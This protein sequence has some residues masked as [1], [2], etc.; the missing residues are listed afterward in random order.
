MKHEIFDN[1]KS[2]FL[3]V[4]GTNQYYAMRVKLSP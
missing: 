4:P 1:C 3:S 2:H